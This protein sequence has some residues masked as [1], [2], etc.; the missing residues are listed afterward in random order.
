MMTL[1]AM[2][3]ISSA[4]V[5][6]DWSPKNSRLGGFPPSNRRRGRWIPPAGGFLLYLALS[7]AFFGR[8]LVPDAGAAY[9]GSGADPG[10][11]IWFLKWWPYAIARGQNPFV[12][13]LVWAPTGANLAGTTAIPALALLAAPITA[14]F[15][16]IVSYNVLYLLAPAVSGWAMFLLVRYLTG[17][18]W[19]AL[20]S[21]YLYGFSSYVLSKMSGHLNLAMVFVPPLVVLLVLRRIE[22]KGSTRAFVALLGAALVFQFLISTE[23]F[24]TMTVFGG[25]A[26]LVGFGL[27]REDRRRLLAAGGAIAA[28]YAA[29]AVVLSPYLYYVFRGLSQPPIYDFYS[30]LFVTDPLNF[31]LPTPLT[32]F[33]SSRFADITARFAGN[34]SEQSAYLGLPLLAIVA[35]Y[36]WRRWRTS[37]GKLLL[38]LLGVLVIATL[39]PKLTVLGR[40]GVFLPWKPFVHIP[41]AKYALPARFALYIALVTAVIVGIWLADRSV[42]PWVKALLV[43]LTVV[44]LLPVWSAQTWVSPAPSP[45]FFGAGL[46]RDHVRQGETVVVIPYGDRGYS[47]LW[48]V[49]SDFWFRMAGG[50]VTVV[51]PKEFTAWPIVRTFYTGALVPDAPRQ[52]RAFLGAH[53]VRQVL[54]ADGGGEFWHGLFRTIDHR[55]QSVGGVTIYRVPDGVLERYGGATPSSPGA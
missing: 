30:T 44:S 3:L 19:A 54:V 37:G 21:G 33:G 17:S 6:Q 42:R 43:P 23:V 26:L 46:Y 10:S 39:G 8:H 24:F 27:M 2:S 5:G 36:G 22:G 34:L 41:L 13:H 20:V 31:V 35:W 53:A 49:Q 7:W 16:P 14:A 15:G 25:L 32:H 51:P 50:Y 1:I 18:G 52:L 28:A 55:P 47:M 9:I 4:A 38:A 45:P 11:L 12:T 40:P 48:Q 29:A